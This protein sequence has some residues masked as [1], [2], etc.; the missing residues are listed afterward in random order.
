MGA[1]QGLAKARGWGIGIGSGCR[2]WGD[3]G[4]VGPGGD[5]AT[6]RRPEAV[7]SLAVFLLQGFAPT[8]W[9]DTCAAAPL[10]PP[11]T[12]FYPP[13]TRPRT[14]PRARWR[15]RRP[16]VRSARGPFD[17]RRRAVT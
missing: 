6:R 16:S 8:C 3:E 10:A 5:E 17:E 2:G 4:G 13:R 9:L 11:A 15:I 7:Q 14:S 1:P 12:R